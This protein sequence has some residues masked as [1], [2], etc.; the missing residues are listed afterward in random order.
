[1]LRQ[2]PDADLPGCYADDE[3]ENDRSLI[4]SDTKTRPLK[5]GTDCQIEFRLI[6]IIPY[7]PGFDLPQGHSFSRYSNQPDC[8]FKGLNASVEE[9]EIV[10]SEVKTGGSVLSVRERAVKKAVE[11]K[12]VS[13]RVF[14]PDLNVDRQKISDR[15]GKHE[16]IE[17]ASQ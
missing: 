6:H 15:G 10:F 14:N 8:V 3:G 11:Q 16:K 1:V 12:R 17:S 2:N 4:T 5:P 7:L 13:W 9:I